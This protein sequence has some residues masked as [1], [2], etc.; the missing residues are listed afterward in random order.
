MQENKLNIKSS[1]FCWVIG[2]LSAQVMATISL[3]IITILAAGNGADEGAIS[4]FIKTDVG[5]LI[6]ALAMDSLFILVSLLFNRKKNNTMFKKPTAKKI[7]FYTLVAIVTFF[8][9]S[10]VVN[11]FTEFLKSCGYVPAELTINNYWL[12]LVSLVVLPAVAEEIFMRGVV[13]KGL[14]PH[15]KAFSILISAVMFTILHG[16]LDQLIYPLIMGILF[17]TIMY[18]E[19]N[20]TYTILVHVI[21]N[22]LALTTQY[23]G[24]NLFVNSWWFVVLAIILVAVIV[25]LLLYMIVKNN[26]QT[27]QEKFTKTDWLCLGGSF[28]IM[29]IFWV[30]SSINI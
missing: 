23:F 19:D 21:N 28:V 20:I 22:F 8:A 11:C 14:K 16:S 25:T 2:F 26:K 9:L 6:S 5:M 17:G 4:T 7:L 12:A 24:I 3:A 15:G 30:L 1:A 10:P 27:K 18:Y 29:I 13:F